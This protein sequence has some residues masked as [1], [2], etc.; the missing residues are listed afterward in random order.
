MTTVD[1]S[2]LLREYRQPGVG[3]DNRALAFLRDDR[4][5]RGGRDLLEFDGHTDAGTS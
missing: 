3:A 4:G 5:V 2:R 1:L